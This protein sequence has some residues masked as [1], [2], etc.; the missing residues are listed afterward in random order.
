MHSFAQNW[1]IP[2]DKKT[3][4]ANFKFTN[5]T[6][7]EGEAIYTKNCM[8]C[9]G[10]LGK[11]NSLKTLNPIPPDLASV[12]TQERTDGELFFIITTGRM[13]M[14]SFK[15]IL[16]EEERWK[17]TSYIRSL[18]KKYVQIV[19]E[20]N[21]SKSNL[22]KI[23]MDFDSLTNKLKVDVK[24]NETS[25]V[26]SL[27]DAEVML[28]VLRYFGKLQIDKTVRTNNEGI[29]T[30]N[31]PKDLPG[32][33]TGNVDLVVKVSDEIYGEVETQSKFKAGIPTDKP[34]LTEKRAI[35]NV[36]KKAP[37]WIIITYTSIVLIVGAVLLYIIYS[38]MKLRKLGN[39]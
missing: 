15:V 20:T 32:D 6:I 23:K 9:H 13:L 2:D 31:F 3:K 11:D 24:A 26:V 16:S 34:S 18:N 14:P 8:S 5:Q 10:N 1:D 22:I 39:N 4:N 25:G 27:K 12:K 30:F 29:A 33:K 17:L 36:L 35:W 21:T 38:L 28:F 37:I 19:S 7:S